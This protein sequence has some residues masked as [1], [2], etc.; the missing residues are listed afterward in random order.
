MKKKNIIVFVIILT[1]VVTLIRNMDFKHIKFPFT[2]SDIVQVEMYRYEGVPSTEECKIITGQED[3]DTLYKEL[4][5]IKVRDKKKDSEPMT[6]GS[7]TRFIFVL[8]D[9][10]RYDLE[11]YNSGGIPSLFSETG[12][13]EYQTSANLEKYWTNLDYELVE[14]EPEMLSI[15]EYNEKYAAKDESGKEDYLED[16]ST[17]MS[18]AYKAALY[19]IRNTHTFPDG[20]NYG[21]DELYDISEN[22]FA[23][24]D[25]DADGKNELLISYWTT[26]MA[27]NVFQIYGYDEI[28]DDLQEEFSEYLGVTF[29]S[30][31]MIEAKKSH[32]HG[33]ASMS[34]EFWPYALYQYDSE[35]DCYIKTADVDAWEQAYRSEYEGI[36]FPKEADIDGDGLLYYI[37]T[38]DTYEYQN[39]MDAEA[40]EKWRDSYLKDAE[41]I[42]I[43]LL[44]LTK[45]NIENIT[46]SSIKIEYS[47]EELIKMAYN[48]ITEETSWN[49]EYYEVEFSA[50]TFRIWL[51]D[52]ISDEES[53]HGVTRGRFEINRKTGL[54]EDSITFEKIDFSKYK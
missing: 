9:G 34:E 2:E 48:Y 37:M 50:D 49:P 53:S 12:N 52:I 8:S 36:E 42:Q 39:P 14:K 21:Y 17:S 23:I 27:G 18:D 43:P 20:V 11:Y 54:G 31:G 16:D 44:R 40:Y 26:S 13:F 51:Y 30:N 45:E 4:Q 10:T 33:L 46:D 19:R 7:S 22:H 35:N 6:G 32:N 47:D 29:Y 3:I 5:N 25:V 1:A 15:D 28:S 41:V 38:N 24:Y